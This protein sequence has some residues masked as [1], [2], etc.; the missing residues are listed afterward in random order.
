MLPDQGF[1]GTGTA[2]GH[3]TRVQP[4]EKL[5]IRGEGGWPM[6]DRKEE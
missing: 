4:G 6:N 5:D 3:S 2:L 1:Y